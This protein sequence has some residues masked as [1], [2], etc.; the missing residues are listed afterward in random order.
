MSTM[1]LFIFSLLALVVHG[2]TVLFQVAPTDCKMNSAFDNSPVSDVSLPEMQCGLNT[3][4]VNKLCSAKAGETITFWFGRA[5]LHD[6]IIDPS[7]KGPV[8]IYMAKLTGYTPPKDGWFKIYERVGD[9]K[10]KWATIELID[11]SGA[12]PVTIPKNI[13][14]GKY[15]IR[16]EYI[17]LH[18]A[19]WLGGV[20]FYID[21]A[22]IEV[23]GGSGTLPS[24]T[25][26]IPGYLKQNDPGLL[27][28]LYSGKTMKDY[29]NP[30][31]AVISFSQPI[32]AR[33]PPSVVASSHVCDVNPSISCQ[34][35]VK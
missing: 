11:R 3:A 5:Q 6:D 1:P 19:N 12:Q 8:N 27:F 30:G 35:F 7:H 28:D 20:Q 22:A 13:P 34:Y 14:D 33:G 18:S 29:Q 26:S 23:L 10:N 4:K 31:P 2:H 25:V 32:V 15:I 17:A 9:G 21:C 16:V 24:N